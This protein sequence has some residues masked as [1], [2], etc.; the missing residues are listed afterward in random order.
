MHRVF[1]VRRY[2]RYKYKRY[3]NETFV[4]FEMKAFKSNSKKK[5]KIM[6]VIFIV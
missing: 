1:S 3:E 4:L 5:K 2:T 6:D